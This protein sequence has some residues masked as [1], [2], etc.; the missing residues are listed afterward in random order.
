M[1]NQLCHY[2]IATGHTRR[3]PRFEVSD[4]IIEVLRP[5]LAAGEHDLPRFPGYRV[6]VTIEGT[7]L[8]ATLLSKCAPLVTTFVVLDEPGLEGVLTVT[9]CKPSGT[10][11]LPAALVETH[12]TLALDQDAV[13]WLGDFERCLAWAWIERRRAN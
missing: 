3:S 9:G 2:T 11:S 7:T 4:G 8:A 12:P 6:R 10:I 1:T 5:L 13:G